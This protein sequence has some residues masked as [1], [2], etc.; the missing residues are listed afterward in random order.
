MTTT[1]LSEANYERAAKLGDLTTLV[2]RWKLSAHNFRLT[3]RPYN[4]GLKNS[5]LDTNGNLQILRTVVSLHLIRRWL[6]GFGSLTENKR[7]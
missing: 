6:F 3:T 2:M 7:Y 5:K 4:K 1:Q